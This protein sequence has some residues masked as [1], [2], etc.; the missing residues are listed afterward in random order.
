MEF[1]FPYKIYSEVFDMKL[2]IDYYVVDPWDFSEYTYTKLEDIKV[3][4]FMLYI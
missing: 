2:D 4:L 1:E 3:V